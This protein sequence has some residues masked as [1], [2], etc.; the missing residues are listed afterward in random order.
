M[1]APLAKTGLGDG[2][3]ANPN[4]V[5]WPVVFGT[6]AA[7]AGV[8]GL[9]WWGM[10]ALDFRLPNPAGRRSKRGRHYRVATRVQ[11]LMFA[12]ADG[13]DV[14]SAG[15]WARDHGYKS[16]DA[17]VTGKYV[18]LRQLDPGKFRVLRTKDFGEGIKA[19]VAR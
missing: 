5:D 17:D 18:R 10:Q 13:W 4:A 9:F 14:E 7:L 16:R 19:V 12:R 8:V 1:D 2:P 15:K 11:S 6:L 3:P